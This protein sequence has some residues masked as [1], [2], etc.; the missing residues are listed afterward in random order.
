MHLIHPFFHPTHPFFGGATPYSPAAIIP[1]RD[2]YDPDVIADISDHRGRMERCFLKYL[3][4]GNLGDETKHQVT[5]L[6][7]HGNV[8]RYLFCRCLQLPPEV[9]LRMS[10]FNCSITYLVVRP[11]GLVS[12]RMLG[13]VGHL[14]YENCSFSMIPGFVW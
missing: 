9:W 14:D 4:R 1:T 2:I 7:C 12:A 6:V 11:N 10:L 5:I 3:S 13:D 8:I